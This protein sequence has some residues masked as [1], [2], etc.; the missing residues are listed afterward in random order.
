MTQIEESLIG[1]ELFR[2]LDS[3]HLSALASGAGLR[4][5]RADE[6]LLAAEQP[7][8]AIYAI[9]SGR[10]AIEI[11]GGNRGPVIIET[12]G[13]GDVVG[14][15]WLLPPYR[16]TFGARA[17]DDV[18]A[19]RLDAVALRELC[20]EQPVFGYELYKRFTRLIHRR[21]VATRLRVIDLYGMDGQKS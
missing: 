13:S 8:D 18:E 11:D 21:L 9:R 2:D 16:W 15:S 5:F 10:V 4:V 17:V 12:I 19:V 6:Y 3:E 7:A 20:D 1:F 14:I